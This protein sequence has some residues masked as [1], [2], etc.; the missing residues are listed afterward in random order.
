MRCLLVLSMSSF[1]AIASAQEPVENSFAR[2]EL[3]YADSA[4][5]LALEARGTIEEP[6]V[7]TESGFIR[8]W[9]PQMTGWMNMDLEGDGGAV[10]F[11]RVRPGADDSGVVVIRIGDGRRVPVTAIGVVRAGNRVVITLPRTALPAAIEAH[12]AAPP[13]PTAVAEP[14]VAAAVTPPPAPTSADDTLTAAEALA[15]VE[16]AP[17]TE[18]TPLTL[19]IA[20]PSGNASFLMLLGITAALAFALGAV[21]WIRSRSAASTNAP[22]IRI[23]ASTRLSQRQQLVVVRALGQDHLISLEPGHTERLLSIP[24]IEAPAG[25]D[26]IPELRLSAPANGAPAPSF[27]AELLRLVDPKPGRAHAATVA[28]AAPPPPPTSNGSNSEAVAGLVRLRA[29]S[30]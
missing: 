30:R 7:R 24:S 23:V 5:D 20:A 21:Q 2:G 22:S 29:A 13:A 28:A 1:T 25:D 12:P 4:I 18:T 11:V 3:Q 17:A 19:G 26:A 16:P 15:G 10:R 6:R 8:L 14:V 9:F 27:A